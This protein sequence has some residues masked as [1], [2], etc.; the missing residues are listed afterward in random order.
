MAMNSLPPFL[1]LPAPELMSCPQNIGF[2]SRI[3][4]IR[5]VCGHSEGYISL[6]FGGGKRKYNST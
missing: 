5:E 1:G 3:L 6:G 4:L 2:Q